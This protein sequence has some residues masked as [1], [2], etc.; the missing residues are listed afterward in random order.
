MI[1]IIT[2]PKTMHIFVMKLSIYKYMK[3]RKE[4]R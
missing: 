2:S 4:V 3:I 1:L